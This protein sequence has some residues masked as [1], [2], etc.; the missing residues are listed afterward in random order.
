MKTAFGPTIC[1]ASGNYF[2]YS[3]PHGSIFYVEDIATSLS[4]ICRYN[5]HCNGFYSVAEHS[6]YVSR[7]VPDWLSLPGLF[8]DGP[9]AFIGD[10]AGPLKLL[11]PDYKKIEATIEDAVAQRFNIPMEHFKHPEV[12][13]ADLRM[14]LTEQKQIMP[15]PEDN[16][17]CTDGLEPADITIVGLNHEAARSLFLNRYYEIIDKMS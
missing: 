3:D 16:W 14:L 4:K 1:L 7:I 2:D 10:M 11:L 6:V 15:N 9:E 12:K 17:P 13:K 5:G 8:H